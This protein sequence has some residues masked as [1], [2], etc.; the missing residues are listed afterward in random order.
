MAKDAYYFPHD[1]NARNDEKIISI[2]MKYGA[3]G[4]GLYWLLIESCASSL[5]FKVSVDEIKS[6]CRE[7]DCP[8][9]IVFDILLN[10]NLFKNTETVYF[11]PVG[12]G[13]TFK[14]RSLRL[15]A[16]RLF[17][18]NVSEW[19]ALR[20]IVFERDKYTCSYCGKVGEKLELDHIIPFS[21]GGSDD[22][23]N[24]T[25]ACR[26]CNRQKRDKSVEDFKKWKL[27]HA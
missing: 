14:R 16:T 4:Y 8:E 9:S 26:R 24:L 7:L 19:Y 5:N 6:I 12:V 18:I 23:D 17:N 15:A 21:K 10:Y 25:T 20:K 27:T 13:F 11:S 2:R 1:S 3:E 22:I